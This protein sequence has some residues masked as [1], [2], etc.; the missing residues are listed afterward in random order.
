M[1]TYP[2]LFD[3]SALF[4]DRP[5]LMDSSVGECLSAMLQEDMLMGSERPYG[6]RLSAAED[7]AVRKQTNKRGC[8]IC[9][10]LK[11]FFRFLFFLLF[12]ALSFT[13][14]AS[15]FLLPLVRRLVGSGASS[16]RLRDKFI[17]KRQRGVHLENNQ[18]SSDVCMRHI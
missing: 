15:Q 7:V 12:F 2:P 6:S 5:E 9:R 3:R 1:S 14:G 8:P 17:E 10:L 4:P 13:F 11:C 18:S 16:Q